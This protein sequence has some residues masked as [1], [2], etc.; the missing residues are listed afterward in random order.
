MMTE[1]DGERGGV[2]QKM[3]DDYGEI[4]DWSIYTLSLI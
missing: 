1:D 4:E 3:M 2:H